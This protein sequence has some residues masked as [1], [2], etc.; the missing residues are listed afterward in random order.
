MTS[1]QEKRE[2]QRRRRLAYLE[3]T[4]RLDEAHQIIE[5]LVALREARVRES[6]HRRQRERRNSGAYGSTI[7]VSKNGVKIGR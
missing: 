7:A 6:Y 2:R 1:A 3:A 4:G 5:E